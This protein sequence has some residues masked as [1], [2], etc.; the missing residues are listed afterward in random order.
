[1]FLYVPDEA[2]PGDPA[3]PQ[4]TVHVNQ[5][6]DDWS[7]GLESTQLATALGITPGELFDANRSRK[8]TLERVE[9]DTPTGEGAHVKR[10]TFRVGDKEGSLTI[11]ALAHVGRA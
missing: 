3:A 2:Q 7:F 10:Y 5:M 9:A 11:E 8:L 4:F 6:Q 1:M